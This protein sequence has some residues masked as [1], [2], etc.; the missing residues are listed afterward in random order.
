MGRLQPAQY[1]GQLVAKAPTIL[2][3]I[4]RGFF[5]YAEWGSLAVGL[6]SLRVTCCG[7]NIF[8]GPLADLLSLLLCKLLLMVTEAAPDPA[9]HQL[10]GD[11]V[12]ADI[13][14][15]ATHVEYPVNPHDQRDTRSRYADTVEHHGEY[16]N[17][18]SRGCR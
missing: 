9:V 12:P 13:D 10:C 3:V 6:F 8:P 11:Q 14:G 16:D 17:A 2:P 15:C 5:V 1:Y 4:R 18:H 7:K